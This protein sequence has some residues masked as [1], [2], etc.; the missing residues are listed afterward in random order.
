MLTPNFAFCHTI[1]LEHWNGREIN[2]DTYS[3]PKTMRGRI[4][5]ENKRTW[6]RTGQ[7]AQEIVA[8]GT[9]FL[10]ASVATEIAPEDRITFNGKQY[11]VISVQLGY[12]INGDITHVEAVIL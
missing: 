5:L 4:N 12:W 8:S 1:E 7:A 3:P 2:R 6:L 9:V 10:P 11:K